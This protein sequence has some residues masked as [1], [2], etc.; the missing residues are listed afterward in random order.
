VRNTSKIKLLFFTP[1]A[2]RTGSEMFLWYMFEHIHKNKIEVNLISE[3]DGELLKM[4]PPHIKTFVSLKYPD[5]VTRL[6]QIPARRL[7]INLYEKH[8]LTIHKKINPDYWYLNT[9]LMTDKVQLAKANNIPVIIHIHELTSDYSLIKKEQL[10]SAVEYATLF[11]ADSKAVFDKLK[12]LGA[13]NIVLQYECI[14]IR[15][16]KVN[17]SNTYRIKEKTKLIGYDFIWLMSGTSNTRKGIDRVPE[18]AGL[19]KERNAALVWLGNNSNT[20]MDLMIEKEITHR[21]LENVCFL[22]KRTDD[23]YDC[24]N[25]ADGFVLTSREEPFGMVVV[26]A[27]A[28]GKPVV[29]FNSGGVSE[30]ITP[31]TG[32]IVDS[33]NMTDLDAAM[34]DVEINIIRFNPE[35][36]K[37]RANDFDVLNQMKNWEKILV[38]L[39]K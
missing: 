11:I 23:Y 21:K 39:A 22:G 4:M 35:K 15:K 25:M 9:V 1:Y 12:M 31:E 26:E 6:K 28:L 38:S 7:G 29:S 17:E 14:D 19:L 34:K 37:Q 27:L 33:W 30:I 8:I 3:C 20:G 24:M 16:I 5:S 13:K 18:L 2:G 32:R 36:A 10:Q